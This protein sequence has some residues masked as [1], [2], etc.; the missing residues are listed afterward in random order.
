MNYVDPDRI[1]AEERAAITDSEWKAS[2]MSD[3]EM[4]RIESRWKSDVDLKLDTLTRSMAE[5]KLSIV[6]LNVV[7][8]TGKG[9][10]MFLFIAAKIMAAIGVIAAGVYATKAWLIR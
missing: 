1:K 10:V 2:A 8:A 7:L 3:E 9:G 6:E 5:L 4:R